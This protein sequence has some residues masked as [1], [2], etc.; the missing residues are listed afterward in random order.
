ML[1]SLLTRVLELEKLEVAPALVKKGSEIWSEWKTLTLA[2]D[3]L[4]DKVTIALVGKYTGLHDSYLSVVKS[5]EHSSMRCGRKLNLI[6]AEAEALEEHM[7]QE[8]PAK[9]HK[10]WHDV[11][12]AE[13]ELP[14]SRCWNEMADLSLAAA[15]WFPVGLGRGGSKGW[16]PP[17]S[18]L[19]PIRRRILV[20][21]LEC[22]LR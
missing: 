10:G 13:Y 15:Y 4:F 9:F 6:W 7:K 1:I 5:L 18:G 12:T 19:G 2:Q 14:L 22:R 21:A 11:C 17:P 16:S 3:R 8:N 20:F